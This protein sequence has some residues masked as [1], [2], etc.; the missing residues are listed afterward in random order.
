[1]SETK[2]KYIDRRSAEAILK[3][4]KI[5]SN[6]KSDHRLMYHI[7]DGEIH[8][9]TDRPGYLI[10]KAGNLIDTYGDKLIELG[11]TNVNIVE[12]EPALI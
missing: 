1:M 6:M 10:G 12:V 8:V 3:E 4:W 2:L 11:A 9:F 5:A 7:K